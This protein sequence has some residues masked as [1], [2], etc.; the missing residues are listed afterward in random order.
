DITQRHNGTTNSAN[1]NTNN[2]EPQKQDQTTQ[3][4]NNPEDQKNPV[5]LQRKL[6]KKDQPAS[7]ARQFT[8][9]RPTAYSEER[10]EI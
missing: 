9:I 6:Q 10:H 2:K 4:N 1:P 5:Y 7:K 8:P 3:N